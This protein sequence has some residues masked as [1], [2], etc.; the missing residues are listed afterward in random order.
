MKDELSEV[1]RGELRWELSH[2]RGFRNQVKR[3]KLTRH[4]VAAVEAESAEQ[5]AEQQKR[6]EER[7]N[8]K[9]G[10]LND[11]RSRWEQRHNSTSQQTQDGGDQ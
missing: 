7:A 9:P 10:T 2:N 8:R 6:D 4:A 3:D 11:G 1:E 5:K